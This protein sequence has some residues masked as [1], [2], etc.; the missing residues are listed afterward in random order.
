MA[1]RASE[2]QAAEA[3]KRAEA[4]FVKEERAKEGAKA[5]LEYQAN[6]RAVREQMARLKALRLAKE[7]AEAAAPA[8]PQP[9][10]PPARSSAKRPAKQP[11]KAARRAKG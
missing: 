3:K 1:T 11:V 5:M 8:V 2:T 6:G 4:N 7:A 9:P 10:K